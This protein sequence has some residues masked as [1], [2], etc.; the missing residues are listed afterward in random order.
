MSTEKCMAFCLW[1]DYP[2]L[3]C[4]STRFVKQIVRE[5]KTLFVAA[6][7]FYLNVEIYWASMPTDR[8]TS[9]AWRTR[10]PAHAFWQRHVFWT[11][12]GF[13]VCLSWDL[14]FPSRGDIHLILVFESF[15]RS[16]PG[17]R[18]RCLYEA[19]CRPDL[20]LQHVHF[21]ERQFDRA[22]MECIFFKA[23]R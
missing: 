6:C 11:C 20:A 1:D 15:E 23:A 7:W 9:S 13:C 18:S 4:D 14:S 8:L 16:F 21:L 5:L 3:G 19:L 10:P 17:M 2:R 12:R 22:V